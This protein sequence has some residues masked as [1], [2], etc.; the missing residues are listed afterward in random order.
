MPALETLRIP[1]SLARP[2]YRRRAMADLRPVELLARLSDPSAA[3]LESRSLHPEA[4]YSYVAL[5]PVR[6]LA[7]WPDHAVAR[8]VATGA[9]TRH[10]DP[11]RFVCEMLETPRAPPVPGAPPF[12]GGWIGT[13]HHETGSW[14]LATPTSQATNDARP[15]L[16]WGFFRLYATVAAFDHRTGELHLMAAPIAG[17]ADPQARLDDL[18]AALGRPA[19]SPAT[20]ARAGETALV[21][22]DASRFAEATT[23]L[24]ALV[25][26]GDCFQ[27]NLTG[28]YAFPWAAKPRRENLVALYDAYAGAN[29]G[30]WA[31]YFSTPHYDLLSSSPEKLVDVHGGRLRLRPIAG[32]RGRGADDHEDRE[33]A[34]DLRTDAKEQA[35]HAMLVDLARNDAARVCGPGSVRITNLGGVERYRHV[36]HLVSEVAGDLRTGV[37]VG[38]VLEA[39]FPGGTVS[40]APKRRALQR[41]AEFE[42]GPRGPYSGTLGYVSVTGDTQWNLLIRTLVALPD[43]LVA[44]AGCGIVEGSRAEAEVEELHAKARAQIQAAL[45]RATAAPVG[46]RCG[47]VEAGP[48]WEPGDARPLSRAA[49]VL[50]VDFEDSFVHNLADYCRRLGAATRVVSAHDAPAP[51]W[52]ERPTHLILSPGPGRPEDFPTGL[53]HLERARA[54]GIPV[55]GVCLGH[56]LLAQAAG[57]R[58]HVH[59]ETVH[60]K[61]SDIVLTPQ[62]EDDVVLGRWTGRRAGRYHSLIADATADLVPLATLAD[63]TLMAA[64]HRREPWWGLQFHP[65]SLLTENGLELVRAFLETRNDA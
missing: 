6:T 27:V 30:P 55:L 49:S 43:A 39:V 57:A 33:R 4:R 50:L 51:A 31:G 29:P 56:Q 17:A 25:R 23:M 47:L 63:G 45:G 52:S 62:G 36:M 14:L 26:A 24:K 21:S 7:L 59:E 3:L 37:T 5:H 22:V 11:W 42:D 58:V 28:S 12:Q 48:A 8:D 10:E 54:A 18:E 64:R 46:A 44:H 61:A 1:Q 40:G 53:D 13:L 15:A 34:H 19:P 9:E 32:T 16:P 35:E 38:E 60:G 41:I 2:G 65:E 20:P